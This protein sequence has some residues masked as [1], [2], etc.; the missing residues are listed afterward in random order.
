[1][2]VGQLGKPPL[3]GLVIRGGV[4][5]RA[6]ADFSVP[7]LRTDSR[8]PCGGS[9]G[10]VGARLMPV[11]LARPGTIGQFAPA[12]SGDACSGLLVT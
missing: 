9:L 7:A 10:R 4:K 8:K 12:A 1:M 11:K 3:P 5:W 6:L 2:L